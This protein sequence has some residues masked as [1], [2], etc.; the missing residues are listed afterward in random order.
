[1]S[2]VE[3]ILQQ[4][5]QELLDLSARNRLL[6]TP[7]Q[8]TR[9][10][11]L[12]VTG[13]RSEAVFRRLVED[14]RGLGFCPRSDPEPDGEE[15]WREDP[16]AG[17]TPPPGGSDGEPGLA[18]PEELRRELWLQTA[19]GAERLQSRLLHLYYD[20]R[21]HDEERGVGV[22]YLALGFLEWY[23]N[24][25]AQQPRRAPLILI[26]VRLERGS[27]AEPFRLWFADEEI[28]TNLALAEKLR[29]DFALN[30]PEIDPAERLEPAAYFR[31]VAAAVRPQPRFRVRADH[32]V[33]GLFSF[34]RILMY[35]DLDPATWPAEMALD[36]RPL[37][38]AL[39][40]EGFRAAPWKAPDGQRL[41][42]LLPPRAALHVLDADASQ[43]VALAAAR[44]GH[45]LLIQGPP[46]TGKSQTIANLIAAAVHAGQ[47]VLFVA[48]KMAALE[49]VK[50]RLDQIGLGELCQEL[51]S[52]RASKRGLLEEL[53]R[54]LQLGAPC[55]HD[56]GDCCEELAVARARL[57]Q[58]AE[59]LHRPVGGAGVTP[60]EAIG[61]LAE[62]QGREA[63]TC[64]IKL[65]GASHWSR[66][67]LRERRDC[68]QALVR[69][70]GELGTPAL[71]PWRGVG[72]QAVLP[73][74]HQAIGQA[75]SALREQLATLLEAARK[76][77]AWL[78]AKPA[79]ATSEQLARLVDSV[80]SLDRLPA[81]IDAAAL[82]SEVWQRDGP[83]IHDL[84]VAGAAFAAVHNELRRVVTEAAWSLDLTA[85]RRDLAAHGGAWWRWCNA[86]WRRARAT[87]R[88]IAKGAPP[89]RLGDQLA[90]LERLIGAQSARQQVLEDDALGRAAFGG[91]WAGE[92]SDWDKLSMV[93]AWRR[94]LPE[95]ALLPCLMRLLA[96]VGDRQPPITLAAHSRRLLQA[97]D[98]GWSALAQQLQLDPGEA[99]GE[100]RIEAVAL[101]RV[102]ERLASWAAQPAAL[103]LWV[104]YCAQRRLAVGLGMCGL[105]YQL[106]H[107]SLPTERA[108]DAFDRAYYE[109]LLR[110]AIAAD[111]A[112][113]AF[114]GREQELLIE[115][116]Q[117]L[118]RERIRI[119]R[120]EVAAAHH[121][122]LPQRG[123]EIGQLGLLEREFAKKR[124]HLPIRQL[125][126]R[127]AQPIQ[128]IKPVFMMSPSSVAEFL[129]PGG[130]RFNLLVIDE[131]S[132]V[133]PVEAFGALA[134]AVQ[135]V[136]VGDRHQLP[137]SRFF[138]AAAGE[139][140]GR[141]SP[142]A[143][144]EA[145]RGGDL[146]SILGA[147]AT[148]GM[149]QRMLRWH[150]RSRHPSLIAV[151]NR[152]FYDDRLHVAP[153][154]F[155]EHP[156]LGL[157]FRHVPDGGF[158]RGGSGVN[159][160]EAELVAAAVIAHARSS[161]ELSLGVG[162]F[163]LCQR[164]AILGQLERLWREEPPEVR[165]VFAATRPE[166]FFVKDVEAIQGDERDVI[167][168]SVGYGRDPS[169]H[170]A[171]S[172]GPLNH[173]GGAR[174]LNVLITRA[175]LR[176]EV[177]ASITADDI[178]L[179]RAGG[180]GVALLKTFLRYAATGALGTEEVSGRGFASPFEA[181]VARA[182]A[183]LGH[184][185][186][187]Q[188]G[189]AG[190]F[191]DLAVRDPERKG[192][193]L[194][195]IECDGAAYHSALW[196]RDRDRLRQ[197]VL[198]DR[199]WIL[200]RIWSADWLRDPAAE[201]GRVATALEEARARWAARDESLE[202]TS[203]AGQ[204]E[205]TLDPPLARALPAEEPAESGLRAE[206]YR[207]ADFPLP[208]VLEPHRLAAAAMAETVARIVEIEG[209]VHGDEIA[210]RV[211]R[212][213]GLERTGRRITEAVNR[214][215]ARA[216]RERRII[217]DGR[218]YALPGAPPI[219][220]DRS[221]V[222]SL[223]RPEMLPPAEIRA[224]VL[225]VASAHYG[226]AP[227]E[228][229]TRVGRL[230]GCATTSARLRA[231]IEAE[232]SR[233]LA[234][235]RL[236]RQGPSL[237]PARP[238]S[239]PAA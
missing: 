122:R 84:V 79:S 158:E 32:I 26:P 37:L 33:L 133:E 42:D 2:D 87:L 214:G 229:A 154:P 198:E 89:R 220:R 93:L 117:E 98:A 65:P 3:R 156:Q 195:G 70:V 128:A 58:H 211:T 21:G 236:D 36:E 153:S 140:D 135:M 80:A 120:R 207:E 178:D 165:E 46:G 112:L 17:L 174:R 132:Q 191:V 187:G 60:F 55:A 143:D 221:A 83:A 239:R 19:L 235:G 144:A 76:L 222:P 63:P 209:P 91:L 134:R 224:A 61:R 11:T 74:D 81:G 200:H 18:H 162:C 8:R 77:E 69:R 147:C 47:T 141:P 108:L 186:E 160:L 39:L 103:D 24:P 146:E 100:P 172:F 85:T 188:V 88:G 127:A 179:A 125:L 203:F 50:G 57:K 66:A 199:G 78:G 124:R 15:E 190:C 119:A 101:T 166:P 40:S 71:S 206:P 22:L 5:R 230:L 192:C 6:D 68:L 157:V 175:R 189:V 234:S 86:A 237:V 118:D 45:N 10:N 23:E 48:Q 113:A 197:Q 59:S 25:A 228:I 155:A 111:P 168:I 44:A 213:A 109:P 138:K 107:G 72:T 227:G 164:D 193:Y 151:A 183:T 96:E 38:R 29:R 115:R 173:E 110:R 210:R 123:G 62:L 90:L 184:E 73:G 159:R 13:E 201:L 97:V 218:F 7:R 12:E 126:A 233:L 34:S 226:A 182:L 212:L 4:T 31:L 149:A 169:G 225:E 43:A 35:R 67:E 196:A 142:E 14:S 139:D 28:A 49:V 130:L 64:A 171:L 75:V 105:A 219:I 1:M 217:R 102:L 106:H 170:L 223:R 54:T 185:V 181:E 136:V 161:P 94:E 121:A 167:L 216:V 129:T 131:A 16:F 238:D 20:A 104:G 231:L 51:H 177:F 30:L 176:L 114:A 148:A 215:L 95:P 150:Y 163:S 145:P 27:A 99:F 208:E 232:T 137:P 194:L 53:E 56:P 205:E 116:F 204:A 152:E 92:R 9:S 180:R 82:Q 202:A 52:P 41:D